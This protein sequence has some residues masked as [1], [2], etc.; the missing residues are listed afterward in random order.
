MVARA[1]A[2]WI[3]AGLPVF[4][5]SS[6]PPPASCALTIRLGESLPGCVRVSTD[7]GR[8][9]LAL[10]PLLPRMLGL[11]P[12]KLALGWHVVT[13][14]AAITVPRSLLLIEAF[15][16]IET[17]LARVEI[18]LRKKE[19]HRQ[20]IPL[21]RLFDP[22]QQGWVSG[23][24]HLHLQK[25]SREESDRYLAE[26]S[27]AD[28][29]EV[30]FVSYLER[31][32]VDRAYITNAYTPADLARLSGPGLVF[33]PGEE[34]R[35]NFGPGGEAYG[36]V[37]MLDLASR[38]LPAS[39]GPGITGVGDDATPLR[40]GLKTARD[41]GATI[42]WCHNA[43]GFEDLPSWLDGIAHAQ[44][45]FD[46]GNKG[47][48]EDTYYRYLNLGMRVPF[49]TGTDWFIYDF[50]RVYVKK[51]GDAAI[52]PKSWLQWLGKGGNVITNGTW[53]EFSV[54]GKDPGSV[55]DLT[56]PGAVSV[57]ARAIG[58]HDFG[59]LEIVHNGRVIQSIPA[60]TVE[61]GHEARWTEP[62]LP[63]DGPCWLAARIQPS[64]EDA[65][66]EFGERLFAH[67]GA[68][69]V[70][71]NGGEVFLPEVA[72]IVRRELEES[73]RQIEEKGRFPDDAARRAVLDLYRDRKMAPR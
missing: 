73:R 67:S 58:R 22:K 71:V 7:G 50:S 11:S 14:E 52:T 44:N 4:A 45:I 33:G 27:R 29:L 5:D 9:W 38:V 66:N 12:E 56:K 42:V 69:H 10:D 18:D 20:E 8:S 47:G 46:G 26:V 64:G 1:L 39:L 55:I 49:S 2:F 63:V 61:G 34:Y 3:A 37:L 62:A 43:F 19:N 24:T 23:N 57:T 60:K 30:V 53:V 68:V 15:S 25:L 40:S 51:K 35:H 28:G 21:R 54:N 65:T 32:V 17:G 36:H 72:E 48:Y 70:R 16:G 59:A 41:G 31:A 13:G 6:P